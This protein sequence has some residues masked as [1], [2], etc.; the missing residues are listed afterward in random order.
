M[1][2]AHVYHKKAAKRQKDMERKMGMD[3]SPPGSEENITP[4]EQWVSQHGYWSDDDAPPGG[5]R[6]QASSSSTYHG[7]GGV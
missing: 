7:M 2:E 6:F 5:S 4:K 3:V 1:Y